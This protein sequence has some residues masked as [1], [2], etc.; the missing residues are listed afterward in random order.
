[1]S[2]VGESTVFFLYL[3]FLSRPFTN[4]RFSGEGEGISLIPLYHFHPLH[5]HLDI[6][7]T[8]TAESSLLYIASYQA[9]VSTLTTKLL[10]LIAKNMS[11]SHKPFCEFSVNRPIKF[12]TFMNEPVTLKINIIFRKFDKVINKD[13]KRYAKTSRVTTE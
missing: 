11:L 12:R 3:G 2:Y 5:R 6:S 4:H 7:Q 9:Q 10:V 8:I 13:K 1:M